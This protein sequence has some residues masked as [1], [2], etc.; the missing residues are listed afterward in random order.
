MLAD[1]TFSSLENKVWLENAA[2]CV[3][4]LIDSLS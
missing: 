3:G 4:K 2:E 1:A